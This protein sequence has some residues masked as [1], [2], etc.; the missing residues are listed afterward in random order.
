MRTPPNWAHLNLDGD[1]ILVVGRRPSPKTL[2]GFVVDLRVDT[3]DVMRGIAEAT[4]DKIVHCEAVEWHPN[5]GIEEGEEYFSVNVEGLPSPRPSSRENNGDSVSTEADSDTS[6]DPYLRE[7]AALLQVVL[8]PGELENLDPA[9]LEEG[10]FR[11]Y[12]IVWEDGDSGRPVAL[13]T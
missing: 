4:I 6:H 1:P 5:A 13:R 9:L 8:A 3:F 12:A 7:A 10:N 11:F 2:E